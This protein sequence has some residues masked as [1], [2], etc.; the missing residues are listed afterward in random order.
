VQ[1]CGKQGVADEIVCGAVLARFGQKICRGKTL[2][3]YP[4]GTDCIQRFSKALGPKILADSA[5]VTKKKKTMQRNA[6]SRVKAIPSTEPAARDEGPRLIPLRAEKDEEVPMSHYLHLADKALG[7]AAKP[8][9]I[10][11][12]ETAEAEDEKKSE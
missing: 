12:E 5:L 1:V 11:K 8:A 7:T 4:T 6:K 3:G 10:K 9:K 2:G